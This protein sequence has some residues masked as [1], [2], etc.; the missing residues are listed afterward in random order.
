MLL[1]MRT[2]IGAAV[3]AGMLGVA[4]AFLAWQ[5]S[6][7][8][9]GDLA[10][11]GPGF[12]PF[13]LG[14]VLLPVACVIGFDSWRSGSSLA[15]ELRHRNVA[16]ATA[17][18]LMVPLLFEPLGAPITLGLF[19]AASLILIGGIS[20]LVAIPASALASIVCWYFFQVLL[21]VQLPA[22]PL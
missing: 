1:L 15:V 13:L 3:I 21:G 22:G 6:L 20:P 12:F 16:I 9:L 10:F 14:A 2:R 5:A 19:G 7:L 17:A 8:G 4:G 11:P 18:L